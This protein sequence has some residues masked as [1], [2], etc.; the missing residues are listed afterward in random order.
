MTNIG[1]YKKN[2]K[3][4]RYKKRSPKPKTYTNNT[5]N[6]IKTQNIARPLLNISCRTEFGSPHVDFERRGHRLP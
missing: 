4:P 5:Q 6:F 1:H 3:S 2:K